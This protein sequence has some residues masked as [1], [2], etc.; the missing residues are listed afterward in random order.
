MSLQTP[1]AVDDESIDF[2]LEQISVP[3][4][5]FEITTISQLPIEQLLANHGKG[6]E[7]SGQKV[8][9]GSLHLAR[10]LVRFSF[11]IINHLVIELGAGTGVL[12]MVCEKLGSQGVIL[13]DNDIRSIDHMQADCLRN[14]ISAHVEI[15]DWFNP[16]LSNI[17]MKLALLNE[18]SLLRVVAGDV[19]YKREL[20]LPFFTTV[21]KLLMLREQSVMFLCHIPR[22][23]VTPD[24]VINAAMLL[25]L[26]IELVE[27]NEEEAV[28]NNNILDYC[29]EDEDVLNAKI[30]E[31]KL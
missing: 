12:G 25:N 10:Y 4:F 26:S 21:Q 2:E 30:F 27:K 1:N 28:D 18:D 3:P 15:V 14:Q 5:S 29:P 8:W 9:C 13:T 19:L 24:D 22:A 6:V 23:G 11:K 20:L 16:D 31:I 17:V 7:I